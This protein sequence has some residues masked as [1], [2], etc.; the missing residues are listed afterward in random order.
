MKKD[1]KLTRL[2]RV[3]LRI[4]EYCYNKEIEFNI[5]SQSNTLKSSIKEVNI[6]GKRIIELKIC[7][8]DHEGFLKEVRSFFKTLKST[9]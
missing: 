3:L 1:D 6:R 8:P 4:N 9:L 5:E 7:N 2:T